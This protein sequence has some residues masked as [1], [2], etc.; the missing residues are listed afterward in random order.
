MSERY[1]P[2]AN[3]PLGSIR[4]TRKIRKRKK[5]KSRR[6]MKGGADASTAADPWPVLENIQLVQRTSLSRIDQIEGKLRELEALLHEGA[7]DPPQS[8]DYKADW[9]S[10]A[11][12]IKLERDP[13]QSL[14][15]G[16]STDPKFIVVR[17]TRFTDGGGNPKSPSVDAI[18]YIEHVPTGKKYNET[19]GFTL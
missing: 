16:D 14:S 6:R 3:N 17:D 15:P 5:E 13:R 18:H 10:S 2:R 19:S 8:E 11:L 9:R 12:R 4:K 1:K 7:A